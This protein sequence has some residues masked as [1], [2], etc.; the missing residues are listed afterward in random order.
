ML[1][2]SEAGAALHATISQ[3]CALEDGALLDAFS[4]E[5]Q[6]EIVRA[7]EKLVRAAKELSS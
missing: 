1:V 5:E 6:E 3:D 7:M 4:P 2:V